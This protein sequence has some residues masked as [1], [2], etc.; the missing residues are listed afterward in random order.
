MLYS[1]ASNT[2]LNHYDYSSHLASVRFILSPHDTVV[3]LFLNHSGSDGVSLFNV[4]KT[5]LNHITG[6]ASPSSIPHT[7]RDLIEHIYSVPDVASYVSYAPGEAL[8]RADVKTAGMISE[9]VS[10][11]DL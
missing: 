9:P 10:H 4:L 6:H 3:L 5:L 11:C 2:A 1:Y 8:F 7:M